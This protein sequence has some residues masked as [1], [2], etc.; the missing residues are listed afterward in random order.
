MVGEGVADEGGEQY[1]D[2][3]VAEHGHALRADYVNQ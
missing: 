1:G 2:D 3:Y